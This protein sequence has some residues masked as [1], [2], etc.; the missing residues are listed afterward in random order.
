MHLI[1]APQENQEENK[2][3]ETLPIPPAV[4]HDWSFCSAPS[5]PI[6]LQLTRMTTV[7]QKP[8]IYLACNLSGYRRMK[9]SAQTGD[10]I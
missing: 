1:H 6:H 5:P 3:M 8:L 10:L 7:L 4:L 9:Y 2:Y